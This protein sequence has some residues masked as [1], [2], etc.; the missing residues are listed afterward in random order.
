MSDTVKKILFRFLAVIGI[1][2]IAFGA[3]MA[4][5]SFIGGSV[6]DASKIAEYLDSVIPSRK[7]GLKE[8]RVNSTMASLSYDGHD[9]VGLIEIDAYSTKL[10]VLSAW[11]NDLLGSVPCLYM[12][13]PHS[14]TTVIG[15][16]DRKGQFDFIDSIDEGTEITLT[17]VKGEVFRYQVTVVRH[18]DD[19]SASILRN[20][21]YDFTI[22][23][24]SG[25]INKYVIVRCNT[26]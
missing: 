18:S 24:K 5:R 20:G 6:G 14:G 17:N 12:G 9:Y 2:V 1:V 13:N 16:S 4:V 10:P 26:K 25:K 11:D 21:E 23:A 3:V 22:F 19:I 15:G 8:D 7:A